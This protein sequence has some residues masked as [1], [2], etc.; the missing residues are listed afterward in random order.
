MV[1]ATPE[2]SVGYTGATGPK[3]EFDT[4][5]GADVAASYTDRTVN[6]NKIAQEIL[7]TQ[8]PPIRLLWIAN[9]NVVSQDFDKNKI[10]KAFEKLE[11][12]VPDGLTLS[13][14]QDQL[15]AT[16]PKLAALR[17]STL[18]SVGV[19]YQEGSFVLSEGAEVSL[20]PPVQ[21]G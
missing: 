21:G 9:K 1:Q 5:Q 12:I 8:D 20:F 19:E 6:I 2:G 13:Q 4:G 17:P 7:D 16:Y 14:L 3:G 15:G 10:L 18:A 11:L